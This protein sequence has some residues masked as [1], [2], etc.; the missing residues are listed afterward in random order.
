[1]V[2]G[3]FFQGLAERGAIAGDVGGVGVRFEFVAARPGVREDAERLAH[4]LKQ[5]AEEHWYEPG[6]SVTN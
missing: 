5:D 6:T 4:W 3:H 2:G 1:M